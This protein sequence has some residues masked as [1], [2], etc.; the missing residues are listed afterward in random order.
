[1]NLS[2]IACTDLKGAISDNNTLPLCKKHE[3]LLKRMTK[4]NTVLMGRK[5]QEFYNKIFPTTRNVIFSR[6]KNY[7]KKEVHVIHNFENGL[8]VLELWEKDFFFIGGGQI[9]KKSLP[10]CDKLYITE[11]QTIF[12][13]PDKYFPEINPKEW[14]LVSE[15][16]HKKDVWNEF[17]FKFKVYERID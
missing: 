16:L 15:V 1:M 10:Y 17:D 14:K 8:N 4:F 12:E 7:A 6:N 9:F 11:F 5:A 13:K 3:Q 2:I